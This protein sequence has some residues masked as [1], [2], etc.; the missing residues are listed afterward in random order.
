MIKILHLCNYTWETGGPPSV[1]HAHAAV[2]NGYQIEQ[3][4][5]SSPNGNQSIYPLGVNQRLFLFKSS[6]LNRILPDFSWS[7]IWFF[8]RNKNQYKYINS[9]GLWNLGSILP[10]LIPNKAKKIVTVHGFL[11]DYVLKKSAFSKRIFWHI[12]QKYCLIKSDV[13]QVI[14]KNEEEFI[15]KN[16]PFL[17]AKCVYVPNGLNLPQLFNEVDLIFKKKLDT[18]LDSNDFVILYLGRINKKKGLD[19]LIPAFKNLLNMTPLKVK[20]LLVGPDDGY[21]TELQNI[22]NSNFEG[23][24]QVEFISSV[25]GS[26]KVYLLQN[27]HA[28]VLPSYSEGFSIAALEAIAYGIPGIYSEVVGFSEDIKRYNAGLLCDLTTDSLTEQLFKLCSN[29]SLRSSISSNGRKLFED[30]YSIEKV[31]VNYINN[32][33]SLK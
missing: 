15:H 21:Q 20:L 27:C 23:N 29:N 13:I 31:A 24:A 4:V 28:F 6:F 18:I 16:F 2:Q 26:E 10:Y 25:R 5:Y 12:I 33:L 8:I 19:L 3:H 1:I 11:D 22:V 7:L 17:A 30:K 9:H 14:S 32:I